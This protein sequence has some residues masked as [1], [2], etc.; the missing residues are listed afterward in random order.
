MTET[1]NKLYE[2]AKQYAKENV[3][4]NCDELKCLAVMLYEFAEQE[5]K[6]LSK[7]ILELQGT[8]G[9]LTDR[10]N[11]LENGIQW[12][13]LRKDPNDL[14]EANWK[15]WVVTVYDGGTLWGRARREECVDG[16]YWVDSFHHAIGNVVLWAKIEFPL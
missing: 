3:K 4:G 5:T 8:N 13:D 14:P 6:L 2:R 11:E 12:H 10:V 9:T 15:N 1:Q 16:V 7:H